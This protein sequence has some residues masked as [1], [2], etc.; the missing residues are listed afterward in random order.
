MGAAS[1]SVTQTESSSDTTESHLSSHV[2]GPG[3]GAV[4]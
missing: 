2:G 3:T 1:A 4:M